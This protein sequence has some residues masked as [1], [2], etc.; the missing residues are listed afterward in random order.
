MVNN[1]QGLPQDNNSPG[2]GEVF[3][4]TN[5]L[6]YHSLHLIYVGELK[7]IDMQDQKKEML[8]P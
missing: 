6:C 5:V 2:K 8:G 1:L 7:D 4:A 3:Q